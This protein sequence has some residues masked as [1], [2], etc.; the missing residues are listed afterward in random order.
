M[1]ELQL[2][3]TLVSS[4]S[5][6]LVTSLFKQV[7][8][9]HKIKALI[10]TV[11]SVVAAAVATWTTGNFEIGNLWEASLGMFALSQA[12]YHLI[13][14]GTKPEAQLAEVGSKRTPPTGTTRV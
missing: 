5:V 1:E 4:A 11:L 8:W 7:E 13:F 6:V 9:S 10:A 2:W 12:F 14:N 3:V